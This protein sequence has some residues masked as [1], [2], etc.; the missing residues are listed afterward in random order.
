MSHQK[1][2][3]PEE[4]GTGLLKFKKEKNYQPKMLFNKNTFHEIKTKKKNP[5]EGKL[6][7][8]VDL[9]FIPIEMLKVVL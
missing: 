4:S 9:K 2:W 3:R 7:E 1:P 8:Y 5:N 6:R